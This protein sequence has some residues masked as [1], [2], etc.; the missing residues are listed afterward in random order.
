MTGARLEELCALETRDVHKRDDGWWL[1]IREGKTEAALRDVPVH[2]S[3]AHVLERRRKSDERFL[4]EGLV[5][6]GPD[7]KRSWNVSKA[8]G[9]YTRKLGLGAERQ[10]FHALRNTFT[11]AM[12]AAEVPESTTKLIIGHK[13]PS[14]TY[15]YYSKGD[16]L[17][18][19][20][21][22]DKVSYSDDVMLLIRRPE[23]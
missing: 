8:F 19:R 23:K 11:E 21:Y 3:A 14:L 16:R 1:T 17:R 18:L 4:F 12:E 10:V 6:G 22:I 5:P 13:R 9:H 7:R 20:K 2:N 15:G